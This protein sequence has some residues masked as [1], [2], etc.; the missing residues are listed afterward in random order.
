MPSGHGKK[1]ASSFG[2]LRLKGKPFPQK[3]GKEGRNPL[4]NQE[5]LISYDESFLGGR[6]VFTEWI[7]FFQTCLI[8]AAGDL[9]GFGLL[10]QR[11]FSVQPVPP[12]ESAPSVSRTTVDG[13]SPLCTRTRW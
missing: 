10:R 13:Q 7:G 8:D 3:R 9:H 5:P 1:R 11:V 12:P 4:G 2:W 6:V